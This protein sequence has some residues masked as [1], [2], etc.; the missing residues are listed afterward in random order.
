MLTQAAMLLQGE[1]VVVERDSETGQPIE[2]GRGAV[3]QVRGIAQALAPVRT[4]V[5]EVVLCLPL[6][7]PG[8]LPLPACI[9]QECTALPDFQHV[10]HAS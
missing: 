4:F 8:I 9:I 3:G 5:H 1:D 2:L 6:A 10:L 7:V